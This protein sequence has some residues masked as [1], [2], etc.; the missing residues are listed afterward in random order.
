MNQVTNLTQHKNIKNQEDW[1]FEDYKYDCQDSGNDYT[2]W[3]SHNSPLT[4]YGGDVYRLV[5]EPDKW[6]MVSGRIDD[7][8]A[9]YEGYEI[10]KYTGHAYS[11]R[12]ARPEEIPESA[13]ELT[14][15]EQI[16][17]QWPDKKVLMFFWDNFNVWCLKK[18]KVEASHVT[19]QSMKGFCTYVYQSDNGIWYTHKRPTVGMKEPI[20]LPVAALFIE[21]D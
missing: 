4:P 16:K 6:Y 19:A 11:I 12:P 21:E 3:I 14:I 5:I 17:A 13:K 10:D 8:E 2:N 9:L 15:E 7:K 1:L 20:Q 18:G